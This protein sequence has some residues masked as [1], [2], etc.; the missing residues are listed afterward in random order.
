[1]GRPVQPQRVARAAAAEAERFL[2]RHLE[3]LQ[4]ERHR[5]TQGV[6]ETETERVDTHARS[7]TLF[8]RLQPKRWN[9][10]GRRVLGVGD[11]PPPPGPHLNTMP[12]PVP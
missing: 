6:T 9:C 12:S 3:H 2:G 10:C 7:R 5:E 11:W 1:M 4:T 8:F